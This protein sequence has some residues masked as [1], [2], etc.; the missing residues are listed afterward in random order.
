MSALDSLGSG[1]SDPGVLPDSRAGVMLPSAMGNSGP[2]SELTKAQR[3]KLVAVLAQQLILIR[4][5]D[6][7]RPGA[8]KADPEE[9]YDTRNQIIMMAV[10][11]AVMAGLDAG[12]GL[13]PPELRPTV[14]YI[15]L[16]TGQVSWHIPPAG[17]QRDGHSAGEKY[18]R[19]DEF[20]NNWWLYV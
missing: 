4:D 15:N 13:N 14:A 19:I 2:G 16:P 6:P 5:L 17:I 11:C 7:A 9:C 3:E 8:N 12:Y 10:T 18:K 20:A 1:N